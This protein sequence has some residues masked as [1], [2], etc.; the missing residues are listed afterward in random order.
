M[1]PSTFTKAILGITAAS[2]LV[3]ALLASG[4]GGTIRKEPGL[5]DLVAAQGVS[6][7]PLA[8]I[9]R[10]PA[11]GAN[12]ALA[13][14]VTQSGAS[15]AIAFAPGREGPVDVM[16]GLER[17]LGGQ[18]M[19]GKSQAGV[20]TPFVITFDSQRFKVDAVEQVDLPLVAGSAASRVLDVVL[21][22]RLNGRSL[23]LIAARLDA[24]TDGDRQRAAEA[25]AKQ[26]LDGRR[27]GVPV[28]LLV[29]GESGDL[30]ADTRAFLTGEGL[31]TT[32]LSK[33]SPRL[34][35]V[36][37]GPGVSVFADRQLENAGR[38]EAPEPFLPGSGG[39]LIEFTL[40]RP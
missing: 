8:A 7:Y 33:M 34:A 20:S 37:H 29:F 38:P 23:R 36:V 15:I 25:V 3:F 27:V 1:H 26:C 19:P 32:E 6:E 24:K 4:C 11:T 17:K 30:A 40:R 35:E 31:T 14:M 12:A 13:D 16:A 9:N 21:T 2:S 22:E 39:S 28:V 18:I 5:I 10:P